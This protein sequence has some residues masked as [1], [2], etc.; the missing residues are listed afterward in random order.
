M[1]LR[2]CAAIAAAI[3]ALA[4]VAAAQQPDTAKKINYA[5][6]YR[7]LGVYDAQSGDPVE[8]VEVSD[9]L[10]GNKALTTSTGTVS[11]MFL[12]EGGGLV[13]L[14]KLGYEVQTLDRK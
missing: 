5:Y 6:R 2:R 13:R 7:L 3:F 9:V 4:R 12:P 14:R 1:I 10:N 11:L 8:G